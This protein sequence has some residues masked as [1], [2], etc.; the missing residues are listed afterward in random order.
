MDQGTTQRR[1]DSWSDV[2][3]LWYE[4][5]NENFLTYSRGD[6]GHGRQKA[7]LLG[8]TNIEIEGD[9]RTQAEAALKQAADKLLANT[10]IENYDV[11]LMG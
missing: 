9:N 5:S 10:L 8:R 11:K 3:I 1:H 6:G 2:P 4:N 7:S